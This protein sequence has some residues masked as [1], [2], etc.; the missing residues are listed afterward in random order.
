MIRTMPWSW[1]VGACERSRQCSFLHSSSHSSHTRSLT[2]AARLARR[3]V[4]SQMY[5]SP[6]HPTLLQVWWKQ[7]TPFTPQAHTSANLT[8]HSRCHTHRWMDPKNI[9]LWQNKCK[10]H[11][12]NTPKWLHWSLAP[13]VWCILPW[14]L[15]DAGWKDSPHKGD[16]SLDCGVRVNPKTN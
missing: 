3:S 9:Q 4:A 10:A 1:Y 5:T 14:I 13:P 16:T 6:T 11:Q 8:T 7:S 12:V 15:M 2:P